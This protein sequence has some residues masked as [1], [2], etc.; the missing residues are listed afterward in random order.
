MSLI[1]QKFHQKLYYY[2]H[3]FISQYLRRDP[4]QSPAP[5]SLQHSHRCR[6]PPLGDGGG[7]KRGWRGETWRVNTGLGGLFLCLR[8]PRHVEPTRKA[9]EGV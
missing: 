4:R 7:A 2:V 9:A 6:H 3:L 5:H 8:W 1:R